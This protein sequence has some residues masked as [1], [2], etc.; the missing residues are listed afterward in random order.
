MSSLLSAA[1]ALVAALAG[2]GDV[3][4]TP[5]RVAFEVEHGRCEDVGG[6]GDVLA[7]V[8]GSHDSSV[9]GPNDST[10]GHLPVRMSE[11]FEMDDDFERVE[12]V[13]VLV[14]LLASAPDFRDY[15]VPRTTS[16][17]APR[18]VRLDGARSLR[19]PPVSA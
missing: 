14:A 1:F 10:H 4:D 13:L 3:S 16:V 17:F 9:H 11:T 6:P 7:T 2:S 5:L 19:G 8:L 15:R 12:R 18:G